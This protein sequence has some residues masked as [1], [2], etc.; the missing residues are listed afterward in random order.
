LWRGRAPVVSQKKTHWCGKCRLFFCNNFAA[1]RVTVVFAMARTQH[2]DREFNMKSFIS[3]ILAGWVFTATLAAL[4]V[5]STDAEAQGRSARS[6][7]VRG[8]VAGTHGQVAGVRSH[9]FRGARVGIVV[10]APIIASPWGRYPYPYSYPYYYGYDP[11]YYPPVAYVQEQP[12]VYLEQQTPPPQQYWYYCQDSKTYFPHVQTCATP[13]Q[14]V[15][16]YAPR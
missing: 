12:A 14:R 10:G 3:S 2:C 1:E 8:H 16:P 4:T 5:A 6:S 7:G 13:W 9:S 15:V 11:Y